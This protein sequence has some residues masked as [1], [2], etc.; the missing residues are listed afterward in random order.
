MLTLLRAIARFPAL[1]DGVAFERAADNYNDGRA[2]TAVARV[3]RGRSAARGCVTVSRFTGIRSFIYRIM[4]V[5]AV[6]AVAGVAATPMAPPARG[7][8]PLKEIGRAHV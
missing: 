4:A 8:S 1:W 3:G 5:T 7:D 6:V 2:V